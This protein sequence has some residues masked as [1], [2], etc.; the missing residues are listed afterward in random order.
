MSSHF[1]SSDISLLKNIYEI[2][3]KEKL[4]EYADSIK[5]QELF[6]NLMLYHGNK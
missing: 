5:F 1:T 4:I 6:N 2:I 3:E